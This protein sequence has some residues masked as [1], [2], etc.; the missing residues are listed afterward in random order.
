MSFFARLFGSADP[1]R[2][3][4]AY[5]GQSP[6]VSFDRQALEALGVRLP[7][8][9]DLDSA[10]VFGRPDAYTTAG[11]GA[12]TLTHAKWGMVLEFE[13]SR[14]VQVTFAIDPEADGASAGWQAA[15]VLGADGRRLSTTATQDEIVERFGTP[16]Q[17]QTFE[18]ETI[19]Y[20]T[21]APLS[22]EFHLDGGR[23]VRWDVYL[24]QP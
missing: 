23:L 15:D 1:T 21:G 22:S 2:D 12:H 6:Q 14:F 4:P 24:N 20:Y 7:F 13:E 17:V 11:T 5:G 19:L 8:G 10:R 18:E 3:W 16:S 9:V